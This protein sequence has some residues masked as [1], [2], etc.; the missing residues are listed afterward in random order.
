MRSAINLRDIIVIIGLSIVFSQVS[1][2]VL[3]TTKRAH[4]LVSSELIHSFEVAETTSFASLPST[5]VLPLA[6]YLPFWMVTLLLI[7]IITNLE[8]RRSRILF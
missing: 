2:W 6:A 5:L 7:R 1:W 4:Q 3:Y 8:K